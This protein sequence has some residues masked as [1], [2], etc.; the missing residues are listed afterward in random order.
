MLML[1]NR[2]PRAI[3]VIVG[4]LAVAEAWGQLKIEGYGD[5]I[6]PDG[7]CRVLNVD[8]KIDLTV[9]GYHDLDPV[10]KNTSGP[11]VVREVEGDF[12]LEDRIARIPRPAKD[13]AIKEKSLFWAAGL[14]VWQDEKNF[15]TLARASNDR[16]EHMF[17][18]TSAFRDGER[19]DGGIGRETTGP[20]V[21]LRLERRDGKLAAF[22]SDD[23]MEWTAVKL[24]MP[25]LGKKLKVGVTMINRTNKDFTAH[26]DEFAVRPIK[27]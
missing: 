11:R 2:F 25:E 7:D 15:V 19:I 3:A 4:L 26:F 16:K 10:A 9:P 1:H 23:G 8:E 14:V 21:S 27:K 22:A 6:D 18:A 5:L 12:V 24:S 20:E 13:G 17:L